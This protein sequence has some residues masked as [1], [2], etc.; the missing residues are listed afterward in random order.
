MIFR[1]ISNNIFSDITPAI[2]PSNTNHFC[3]NKNI[4]TLFNEMNFKL[5][6][7]PD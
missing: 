2:F 7:I 6:N 5:K 3:R 4:N 1:M